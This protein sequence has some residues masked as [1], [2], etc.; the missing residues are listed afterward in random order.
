MALRTPISRVRS[1]TETNM[2][3]MM[4]MPPTNSDRPVMN[5]P[6][7]VDGAGDLVKHVQKLILL[8]DGEIVRVARR[9]VAEAP[10]HDAQFFFRVIQFGRGFAPSPGCRNPGRR[11]NARVNCVMRHDDFV[12]R[13]AALGEAALFFQHADDFKIMAVGGNDFAD[14]RFA[15]EKIRG[16]IGTDDADRPAAVTFRRREKA[17][18][19]DA[20][21]RW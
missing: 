18:F 20:S 16:E 4:P 12:V 1:A 11:Q 10:Q 5:R 8:V 7:P 9:E 6:M 2:M 15:L 13:A 3:F 19:R 21:T 17:S 14:G